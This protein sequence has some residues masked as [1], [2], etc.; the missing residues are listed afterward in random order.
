MA[1][2]GARFL[3]PHQVTSLSALDEQVRA[4]LTFQSYDHAQWLLAFS[5]EDTLARFIAQSAVFRRARK[6]TWL[7]FSD[8]V[9]FWVKTVSDKSLFAEHETEVVHQNVLRE[10]AKEGAGLGSKSTELVL[11][12]AET[13]IAVA[14]PSAADQG[15]QSQLRKLAESQDDKCRITYEA[16]QAI[17]GTI[18]K[19][20]FCQKKSFINQRVQT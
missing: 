4:Q 6:K 3:R 11:K 7:G 12:K 8:Q 14:K 17:S 2:T 10:A 20:R 9:P 5:P 15:G 18:T 1:K 16:R 13:Q 19:L